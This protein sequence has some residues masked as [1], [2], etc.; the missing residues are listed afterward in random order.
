LSSY[1]AGFNPG[2]IAG[3]FY[4]L[5]EFL[6]R[7]RAPSNVADVEPP[8]I[9]CEIVAPEHRG[10]IRGDMVDEIIKITATIIILGVL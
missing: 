7:H 4:R 3:G 9:I 10:G 5:L 1:I 8:E 2:L 6:W